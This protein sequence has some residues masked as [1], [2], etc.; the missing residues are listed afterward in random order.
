MEADFR[1]T[2]FSVASAPPPPPP[3][4]SVVATGPGREA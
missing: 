4:P 1:C 2:N 3:L